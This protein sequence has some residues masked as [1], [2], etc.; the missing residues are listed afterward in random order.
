MTLKWI[1]AGVALLALLATP[2]AAEAADKPVKPVYKATP[3]SVVPYYMWQG[4]YGGF[5]CGYGFGTS[6]WVTPA[7]SMSPKGFLVG[8]TVG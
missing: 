7:G 4:L 8:P 1:K 6:S 2:L 3:R 5:N